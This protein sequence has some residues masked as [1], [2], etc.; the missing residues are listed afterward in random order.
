MLNHYKSGS[1]NIL[2]DRCAKKL[3][4][5]DE[6]KETWDGLRV[7]AEGGCF[8]NRHIADFIRPPKEQISVPYTRPQ[9]IDQFTTVTYISE[10]IG[11]QT[12]SIPRGTSGNGTTL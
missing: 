3:K 7:C 6:V 1:W 4:A 8:E 12:S 2:C 10:S 11:N 5:P 9:P